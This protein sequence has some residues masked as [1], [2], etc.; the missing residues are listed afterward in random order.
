MY[1]ENQTTEGNSRHFLSVLVGMLIG[2]LAGA[3]T[4]LFIAPQS[5]KATR[6]LIQEKGIHLRDQVSDMMEVAIAQVSK[7]RKK[8]TMEGQKKAGEIFH[9]GQA[10]VVEQLEH[11][12]E[13]A[14]AGKKAI[15]S[16]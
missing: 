2:S 15:L 1:A 12:S 5:G 14:L 7:D 4:M 9:S 6:I 16:S 13:A 8:I 3:L 10:L 11:V